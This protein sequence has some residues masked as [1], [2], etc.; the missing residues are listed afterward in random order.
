MSGYEWYTVPATDVPAT[1]YFQGGL[2]NTAIFRNLSTVATAYVVLR[3]QDG[4][5]YV[6]YAGESFI[7]E[8][9]DTS[10]QADTG[11]IYGAEYDIW[12]D[13]ANEQ[14]IKVIWTNKAPIHDRE[15]VTV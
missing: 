6:L 4:A 2:V 13:A 1:H 11:K 9:S 15:P 5:Q 14:L 7:L 10:A 8:A 3:F 12:G